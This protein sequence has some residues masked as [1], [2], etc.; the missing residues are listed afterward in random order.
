MSDDRLARVALSRLVEPGNPAVWEAVAERGPVA[1]WDA[2]RTGAPLPGLSA[3]M[4]QGAAARAGGHDPARD[5]EALERL[6]GRLVCPGDPEW[7]EHRLTW[8]GCVYAPPLALF[9]RGPRSL[10]ETVERSVAVVGA[11]AAT[12]YGVHVAGELGLGLADRACAVVS[13]GAYGIDAAAHRGALLSDRGTTIAVL[14]CGIDV[15]YPRGNDRLLDT[16]GSQ[17]L[18]VSELPPGC[19]PTRIRF[20]VRNR[21]IAALTL[22]TVVVEA[23]VRSGS[24]ATAARARDLNRFVMAVPGP[25][26]SAMSAGAHAELRRPDTAC[27]TS[28]AEILDTVGRLGDDAVDPARAR[29]SLRDQLD[30]TTRRVLDALP[31]RSGAGE[32]SI[33]KTAGVSSLVVQQV[34]PPLLVAGLVE[35]IDSGWRLTPMGAERPAPQ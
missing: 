34:L 33:A 14:A 35:R 4:S 31:V 22:G 18:L 12:A 21:I 11:R 30:E 8:S 23:A 15:A 5:L 16:I 6:G 29:P 17:G 20:L 32:A 25:V 10:A 1:T 19:S 27:V 28:A 9:V 7:P 3:A 24:L 2:V 26:T 13:G